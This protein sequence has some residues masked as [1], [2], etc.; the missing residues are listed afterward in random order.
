MITLEL[1]ELYTKFTNDV[2]ATTAFG[3]QV[4]TFKEPDNLFFKMGHKAISFGEGWGFVRFFIISVFPKL[5]KVNT[6]YIAF[7]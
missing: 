5:A 3:L 1:K 2:I 4:D 6:Y 7:K